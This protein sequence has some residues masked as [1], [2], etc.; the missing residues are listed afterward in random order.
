MSNAYICPDVAIM[1]IFNTFSSLIVN[2]G[3]NFFTYHVL[4]PLPLFRYFVAHKRINMTHLEIFFLSDMILFIIIY[5]MSSWKLLNILKVISTMAVN[6]YFYTANQ[7]RIVQEFE[8][9]KMLLNFFTFCVIKTYFFMP[10]KENYCKNTDFLL[11]KV[12]RWKWLDETC[13]QSSRL[14]LVKTVN[15]NNKWFSLVPFGIYSPWLLWK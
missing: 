14:K 1:R 7:F 11:A 3:R 15:N 13:L 12:T 4:F 5:K 2:I 10:Y 8:L 6:E 9:N